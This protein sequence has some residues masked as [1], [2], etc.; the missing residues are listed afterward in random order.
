MARLENLEADLRVRIRHSLVFSALG[1]VLSF[2]LVVTP[3][4]QVTSGASTAM[5]LLH[6]ILG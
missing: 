2:A 3:L 4:T 6:L 1:L 5:K